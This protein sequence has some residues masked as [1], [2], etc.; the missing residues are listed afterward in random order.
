MQAVLPGSAV[1]VLSF[2][3]GLLLRLLPE[4]IAGA[5][6][7]GFRCHGVSFGSGDR[8]LKATYRVSRRRE[9]LP[10]HRGGSEAGAPSSEIAELY[11]QIRELVARS[12]NEPA[13]RDEIGSKM[14]RLRSLQEAESE[15]LERRFEEQLHLKSGTGWA[16]LQ[17]IRER[18][19]RS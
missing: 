9:E 1:R 7:S 17:R 5:W 3:R 14:Q 6:L 2:L 12:A 18:L 11:A 16:H 15:A 13:L 4:R 19:G 10:T 8:R